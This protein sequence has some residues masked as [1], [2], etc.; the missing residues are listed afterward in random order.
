MLCKIQDLDIIKEEYVKVFGESFEVLESVILLI[1][2]L[3][4]EDIF[5]RVTNVKINS[6]EVLI[7]N[8]INVIIGRIYV[9]KNCNMG[10][11]E[12]KLH[13]R[14]TAKI[15]IPNYKEFFESCCGQTDESIFKAVITMM[16][17]KKKD[18]ERR[19]KNTRRRKYDPS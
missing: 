4:D 15:D 6:G 16:K 10:Y 11:I 9:I 14:T 19:K 8:K 7:Y 12:Y 3:R 5:R 1:N 17:W 13:D 2:I 18:W